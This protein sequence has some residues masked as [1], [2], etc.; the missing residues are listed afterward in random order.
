MSTRDRYDD[1]EGEWSEDLDYV[2][3]VDVP[4]SSRGGRTKGGDYN[5]PYGTKEHNPNDPQYKDF[6]RR[7][8]H[9]DSGDDLNFAPSDESSGSWATPERDSKKKGSNR[10]RAGSGTRESSPE[11]NRDGDGDSDNNAEKLV[12]AETQNI[13]S[14]VRVVTFK[15]TDSKLGIQFGLKTSR[16]TGPLV[17]IASVEKY[18]LADEKGIKEDWVLTH[19]DREPINVNTGEDFNEFITEVAKKRS[20]GLILSFNTLLLPRL[21]RR[22]T[23]TDRVN[24]HEEED[25]RNSSLSIREREVAGRELEKAMYLARRRK[26]DDLSLMKLRMA[27]EQAKK[28]DISTRREGENLKKWELLSMFEKLGRWQDPDHARDMTEYEKEITDLEKRIGHLENAVER[29]RTLR[30]SEKE[31][32][33]VKGAMTTIWKLRRIYHYCKKL[34]PLSKETRFFLMRI[35]ELYLEYDR[36]QNDGGLD[37][38]I[39]DLK[40][41]VSIAVRNAIDS[42]KPVA[43]KVSIAL[44]KKTNVETSY[45]QEVNDVIEGITEQSLKLNTKMMEVSA[46]HAEELNIDCMHV[47]ELA[48]FLKTQKVRVIVRC[49]DHRDREQTSRRSSRRGRNKQEKPWRDWQ[50]KMLKFDTVRDLKLEVSKEHEM[51]FFSQQWR[52]EGQEI[53]DEKETLERLG[54]KNKSE[55]DVIITDDFKERWVT[56]ELIDE[57]VRLE[58]D[59]DEAME[60]TKERLICAI[61]DSDFNNFLRFSSMLRKQWCKQSSVKESREK[62]QNNERHK[63]RERQREARH[64]HR[65][66]RSGSYTPPGNSGYRKYERDRNPNDY[67][68]TYG[69]ARPSLRKEWEEF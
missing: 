68:R 16:F 55:I 21:K 35:Q 48:S 62:L 46:Q 50:F 11:F 59:L 19:L 69:S 27:I 13:T 30:L 6:P 9:K 39:R 29:S 14:A 52:F 31:E 1:D 65:L 5:S 38:H 37:S 18:S 43:L 56:K 25:L 17:T 63:E 40:K 8:E 3:N 4:E 33:K 32:R 2:E 26:G 10:M 66:S 23:T 42:Q 34:G 57:M 54:V 67:A 15:A 47:K 64:K 36:L 51:T 44:A 49:F 41:K 12:S 60:E 28:A 22:I 24:P 53:V 7:M 45:I 58:N 61:Q 20:K